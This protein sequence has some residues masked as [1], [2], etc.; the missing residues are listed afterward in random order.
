MN[1]LPPKSR[2]TVVC[3][4]AIAL[5]C[6]AAPFAAQAKDNW[7]S[8]QTRN[9][10]VVG[11][12]SEKEVKQVATRLEQFREVFTR[13]FGGIKFKSPVPTTVIVFKSMSSYKPFRLPNAAG[14]FQ[15][16]EDVNYITLTTELDAQ[17]PFSVIYHE[18]VHLLIDNTSGNVPA[19]F[20]EGLGEYYSSFVVE[21]DRKVHLGQLLNDHLMSLR[22]SR[23]FPRRKL[24]E[25]GSLSP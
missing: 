6:L 4:V 7:I 14:Y 24:F 18:Y 22:E 1:F 16:G 21:E 20:N 19:W 8:V 9:F 5:I 23:L 13:L 11:N 15:K 12:G 25:V 17:N 2:Q 3:A 10:F